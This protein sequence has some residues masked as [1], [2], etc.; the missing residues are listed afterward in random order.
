MRKSPIGRSGPSAAEEVQ[1]DLPR[2]P[3]GQRRLREHIRALEEQLA[4]ARTPK[5]PVRHVL[6]RPTSQ[7]GWSLAGTCAASLLAFK[8]DVVTCRKI[9]PKC[10]CSGTQDGASH[11]V[12]P[13]NLLPSPPERWMQKFSS[14]HSLPINLRSNFGPVTK[15]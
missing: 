7:W 9:P 4:F 5:P 14:N 11:H 1:L 3:V 8:F 15:K 6:S 10:Q 2:S 12:T 13:P